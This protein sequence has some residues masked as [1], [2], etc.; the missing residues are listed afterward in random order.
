MGRALGCMGMRYEDFLHCTP[1]EFKAACDAWENE[2]IHNMRDNW[3]RT[4]MSCLCSIQPYSEKKLKPE[5]I[6]QFAWDE[7]CETKAKKEWTAEELAA[8]KARYEAAK[9]ARGII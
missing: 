4:R 2:R 9:K 1:V 7:A 6:M 5:D 8:E 3:E